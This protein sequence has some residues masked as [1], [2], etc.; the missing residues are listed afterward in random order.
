MFGRIQWSHAINGTNRVYRY[1]PDDGGLPEDF[2][3]SNGTPCDKFYEV[4]D[5]LTNS[6]VAVRQII[7]YVLGRRER[8]SQ[9]EQRVTFERTYLGEALKEGINLQQLYS[10]YPEE[11]PSGKASIFDVVAYVSLSTPTEEY[12]DELAYTLSDNLVNYVKDRIV[13]LSSEEESHR[14]VSE[15]LCQQL[16][17]FAQNIDGYL[18]VSGSSF[19]NKL[20]TVLLPV[21]N[22]ADKDEYVEVEKAAM[23]I[24]RKLG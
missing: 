4:L 9:Q 15:V 21:L 23:Y 12:I 20:N 17:M 10:T 11:F 22:L 16:E 8:R 3:V 19:A 2:I 7:S 1:K 6:P 5:A 14:N 13:L 18:A 24:S